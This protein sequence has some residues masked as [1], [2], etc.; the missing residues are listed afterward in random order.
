MHVYSKS[1]A[2]SYG[3]NVHVLLPCADPAWGAG[4]SDPQENHKNI[5]FLSNTGPG[6][7]KITNLPSQ[8][9]MFGHHRH[10]S[11]TPF[12]SLAGQ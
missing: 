4:G 10:A 5:G 12:N 3:D 1:A 6:S 11:E 8:H 2:T 9:S 7:Q